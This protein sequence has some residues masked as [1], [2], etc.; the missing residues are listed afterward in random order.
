[1]LQFQ[2]Y[3]TFSPSSFLYSRIHEPY[4]K[5]ESMTALCRCIFVIL[6]VILRLFPNSF[7]VCHCSDCCCNSY[8]DFLVAFSIFSQLSL[9]LLRSL[10][11]CHN[12]LLCICLQLILFFSL[13]TSIPYTDDHVS[14]LYVSCCSSVV[15]CCSSSF[16]ITIRT[17]SSVNSD[18]IYCNHLLKSTR[19]AWLFSKNM[20][21]SVGDKSHP[22][23]IPKDILKKSR[24]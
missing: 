21:K 18:Y 1:M 6:R 23:R 7:K 22:R 5:M 3:L 4:N 24:I 11:S 9:V 15:S 2:K 12:L 8:L 17:M 20:L 19:L 10:L 13:L 16:E 14:S